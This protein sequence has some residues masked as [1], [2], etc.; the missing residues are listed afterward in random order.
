MPCWPLWRCRAFGAGRTARRWRRS[1]Q[2]RRLCDGAEIVVSTGGKRQ[3]AGANDASELGKLCFYQCSSI[4]CRAQKPGELPSLSDGWDTP[5][6]VTVAGGV[7]DT[8]DDVGDR[9]APQTEGAAGG[10]EPMF[11][12]A[13]YRP[14]ASTAT[15]AVASCRSAILD[16]GEAMVFR[17][18]RRAAH[19]PARDGLEMAPRRVEDLLALALK[20][21]AER[22]PASRFRRSSGR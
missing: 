16:P 12:T 19:C 2:E 8:M 17:L 21:P 18:A 20:T 10:G 3:R 11:A 22:R 13:T 4:D 9:G 5:T 1:L 15:A 6:A 14:P 7:G